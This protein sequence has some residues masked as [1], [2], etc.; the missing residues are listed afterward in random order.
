MRVQVSALATPHLYILMPCREAQGIFS[1]G[2]AGKLIFS[3]VTGSP[4]DVER[5]YYYRD[6]K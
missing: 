5:H 1:A 6:L 2:G 4:P 3:T